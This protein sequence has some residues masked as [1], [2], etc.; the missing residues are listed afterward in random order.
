MTEEISVSSDGRA[1]VD[2]RVGAG[3]ATKGPGACLAAS[4]YPG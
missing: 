3:T 4:R 2:S 1:I